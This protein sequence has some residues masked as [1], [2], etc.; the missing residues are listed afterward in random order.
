MRHV[1]KPL[2][3]NEL[4]KAS[5]GQAMN[6]TIMD[7]IKICDELSSCCDNCVLE[8]G[9]LLVFRKGDTG[10]AP[11]FRSTPTELRAFLK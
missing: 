5:N 9:D 2:S 11:V 4:E 3:L 6:V 10:F 1:R 7:V 8:D